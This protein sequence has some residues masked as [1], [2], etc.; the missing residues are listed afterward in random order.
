MNQSSGARNNA[1]A[2]PPGRVRLRDVADVAEVSVSVVSRVL[3]EDPTLRIREEKRERVRE[4]AHELGYRPNAAGRSLRTHTTGAIGVMLPK[5]TQPFF[6]DVIQG[7]EDECDRSDLTPILGRSERLLSGSALLERMVGEG[8]VDG[9]VLQLPEELA[10]G[11]INR[12]LDPAVPRVLIQN[13]AMGYP[14]SV[15]L[16]VEEAIQV[17]ADHLLRLGHRDIALATGH[18]NLDLART[19]EAAFRRAM[20]SAGLA[21]DEAWISR[22]GF[23]FEAGQRAFDSIWNSGRHPT[24]ILAA[25]VNLGLGVMK[26]ALLAQI[27]VPDQVSVLAVH[28]C[29]CALQTSP[30][31]SVVRLPLYRLGRVAVRHLRELLQGGQPRVIAVTDPAPQLVV[32]QSTCPPAQTAAD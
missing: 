8:R 28:D 16:D 32:R 2:A 3:N 26:S 1:A 6:A 13:H 20:A 17:G 12:L 10:D 25:D 24:A 18:P 14:G 19:C 4:V 21:V 7:V 22:T 5:L 29:E 27:S 23:D 11:D 9:F 30:A 31:L 15:T